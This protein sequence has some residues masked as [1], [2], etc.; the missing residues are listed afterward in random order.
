[1][2]MVSEGISSMTAFSN[3]KTDGQ[4]ARANVAAT[5]AGREC[6]LSMRR[7][8]NHK[9]NAA[10]A[11]IEVRAQITDIPKSLKKTPSQI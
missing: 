5:A 2:H 10:K 11:I 4:N 6:R 8:Q 3:S 9:P 7:N 1:M